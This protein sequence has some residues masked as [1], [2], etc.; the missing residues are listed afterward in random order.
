MSGNLINEFKYYQNTGTHRFVWDA[1]NVS[2][3]IYLI[4]F[5]AEASDGS[6]TFVDY[7]KVTLLK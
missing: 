1:S 2:S 7:Q 4:R 3:G 5:V 6:E